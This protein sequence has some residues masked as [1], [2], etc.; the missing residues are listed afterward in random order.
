M[1]AFSSRLRKR[2]SLAVVSAGVVLLGAVGAGPA[3]AWG[4][5]DGDG[6][7]PPGSGPNQDPVVFELGTQPPP[8]SVG[9][10]GTAFVLGGQP[11]NPNPDLK[12]KPTQLKDDEPNARPLQEPGRPRTPPRAAP[13]SA[14]D[15]PPDR[16]TAGAGPSDLSRARL[17]CRVRSAAGDRGDDR[18]LGAVGR[19][20]R[21][22]VEEP[23][24]VVAD[25]DV[26]EP[27][28]LAAVVE[29]PAL[30]ARVVASRSSRTS[31]RLPPAAVTSDSPSV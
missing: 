29:D 11:A 27:A 6:Q 22:V 7:P 31:A 4:L 30:D 15:Q 2:R 10:G 19:R 3:I 8:G 20:R 25:V 18:D 16:T 1:F 23:H 12:G 21:Q 14:T 17:L 26:D 9:S 13:T 24:V 5:P 28:Q